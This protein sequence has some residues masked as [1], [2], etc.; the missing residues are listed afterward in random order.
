MADTTNTEQSLPEAG[1]MDNIFLTEARVYIAGVLMPTYNVTITAM[2]NRAPVAEIMLPPYP[3][4]MYLG[5]LDKVPVHIFVRETMVESPNFILM[6]EGYI[7]STNYAQNALTR[8]VAIV[9]TSFMDI[10]GEIRIDLMNSIEDMFTHTIPG[11]AEISEAVTQF[12]VG[13]PYCFFNYGLLPPGGETQKEAKFICF[14]SDFLKNIY[15]FVQLAKPFNYDNITDPENPPLGPTH[16]S[17]IT[18]FWGPY[19]R[20]IKLLQRFARLPYFDGVGKNPNFAWQI[21]TVTTGGPDEQRATCFPLLYGMKQSLA[22]QV[23]K[24]NLSESVPTSGTLANILQWMIDELEYEYLCIT[25]P[26]YHAGRAERD[27]PRNEFGEPGTVIKVDPEDTESDADEYMDEIE[28]DEQLEA[29]PK[30]VTSCLKPLLSDTFPPACNI[31]YRTLVESISTQILHKDIPTRVQVTNPFWQ[32]VFAGRNPSEQQPFLYTMSVFG[33]THFYPSRKYAKFE[34]A[35]N[36]E[37]RFMRRMANELLEDEKFVGPCVR[38]LQAPKWFQYVQF[39]DEMVTTSV[40]EATPQEVF[41][42]RFMRRQLLNSKYFERQMQVSSTFDPYITPGFPGV[43]FDMGDPGIAFAGHVISVSHTINPADVRTNVT[44]NFVRTLNEAAR[45]AIPNPLTQVQQITHEPQYLE[46]I[47]QA[48]LGTPGAGLQGTRALTFQNIEALDESDENAN[49][50]AAYK[51]KRRNI[52]TFENYLSFMRMSATTGEGPEGPDTPVMIS[53]RLV[54]ERRPLDV[55]LKEAV[56]EYEELLPVEGQ[57]VERGEKGELPEKKKAEE[58]KK[59]EETKKTE[60]KKPEE[61]IQENA[62]KRIKNRKV[63]KVTTSVDVRKLLRNI[64]IKCFEK[65][66]YK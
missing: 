24:Q 51:S 31:I 35:T 40:G 60:E 37:Y 46:E 59:P 39:M 8:T 55:F 58:Q 10:L 54:N 7:V 13:F 1:E 34:D 63:T 56:F 14:P 41:C 23:L 50:A 42:E 2:F 26:A 43:V 3:E 33:N 66:V 65:I 27:D 53:G 16:G 57:T 49:P 4:L 11:K 21:G 15:G 9:A 17:L 22:I 25:N 52:C 48:I 12:S 61:N 44:F 45:I 20:K 6:F 62:E 5:D 36:P 64:A 30:L 29:A 47:Y 38:Q 18:K 19:A 32:H 28:T